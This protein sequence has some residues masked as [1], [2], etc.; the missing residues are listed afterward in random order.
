[1]CVGTREWAAGV[2]IESN[3]LELNSMDVDKERSRC[4]CQRANKHMNG[5][6]PFIYEEG[7]VDPVEEGQAG[8][9]LE[10]PLH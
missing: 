8:R 6:D 3:R 10:C 4:Q 9:L 5:C 2:G 7:S 1:M